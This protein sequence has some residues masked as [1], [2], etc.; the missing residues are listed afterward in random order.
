MLS[1]FLRAHKD[2]GG[3]GLHSGQIW[4]NKDIPSIVP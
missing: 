1:H 2:V 4:N 3:T